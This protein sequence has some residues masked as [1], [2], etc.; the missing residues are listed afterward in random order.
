MKKPEGDFLKRINFRQKIQYLPHNLQRNTEHQEGEDGGAQDE[1]VPT[2]G[3]K[4]VVGLHCMKDICFGCHIV[5]SNIQE[6]K[7]RKDF[8]K[9]Y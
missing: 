2:K 6:N 9:F 3:G 7:M 1:A 8:T 5:H 4:T